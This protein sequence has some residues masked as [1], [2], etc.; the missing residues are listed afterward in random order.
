M[1]TY[2]VVDLTGDKYLNPDG[3]VWNDGEGSH[4]RAVGQITSISVHHD[5]ANR[6]HD[7]DSVGR[8][9]AEAAEHYQRLG[10]GLQYHA[11]IDNQGTIFLIRPFTTWLNVVGSSANVST[12][13]VC[14]DGDFQTGQQ[15]PTQ[16][17]YE[18]LKQLLDELSTQHPEFP[19]NQSNVYPHRFFSAT[20]CCGDNLVPFVDS[21]RNN[22]GNVEIPQ[23]GYDWPSMQ[24][25]QP[26]PAPAPDVSALPVMTHPASTP[27]PEPTPPTYWRLKDQTGTQLAAYSNEANALAGWGERGNSQDIRIISPDGTDVTPAPQ[28]PAGGQ[29]GSV[30]TP[31]PEPASVPAVE[32]MVVGNSAT[33]PAQG[34]ALDIIP[35]SGTATL[36]KA[37]KI[38]DLLTLQPVGIVAASDLNPKTLTIKGSVEVD[39]LWYLLT[40]NMVDATANGVYHGIR[41]SDF[42]PK[43][44]ATAVQV[45]SGFFNSI[46][47]FLSGLWPF[48]H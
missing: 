15:Q 36:G 6:P 41:V 7:Y 11:K 48:K 1:K 13:A 12:L 25:N 14:L 8:Y 31:T 10:N 24:P 43:Q 38:Y 39:G 5:A 32:P 19:A 18:A 16:E 34:G 44:D 29:G 21:Y 4:E 33:P 22:G 28:P 17:Q 2:P 26:V 3:Y 37:A 30:P 9:H 47:K 46:S 40:Q 23:V 45:E 35:R 27:A 42:L 20:D